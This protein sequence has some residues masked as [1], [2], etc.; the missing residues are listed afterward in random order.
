M[1]KEVIVACFVYRLL[2]QDLSGETEE[3]SENRIAGCRGEVPNQN[4]PNMKW[5]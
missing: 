3:Y 2:F 1:W 4:L 5:E